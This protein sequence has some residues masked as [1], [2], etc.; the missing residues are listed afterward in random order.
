MSSDPSNLNP[1]SDAPSDH[2]Q[3]YDY[4]KETGDPGLGNLNPATSPESDAG[5]QEGAADSEGD[6]D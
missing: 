6:S 2:D 1:F 5:Q 4:G 3:G